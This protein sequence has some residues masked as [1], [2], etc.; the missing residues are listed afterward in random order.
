ME[1][2]QPSASTLTFCL[3]TSVLLLSSPAAGQEVDAGLEIPTAISAELDTK[4]LPRADQD[5]VLP[6]QYVTSG[7]AS[8]QRG[9]TAYHD[10]N[11]ELA[12]NEFRK[13]MNRYGSTVLGSRFGGAEGV[14][15]LFRAG[16]FRQTGSRIRDRQ[17]R[18]RGVSKLEDSYALTSYA[19][20][21][22]LIKQ[23][24]YAE[25]RRYFSKALGYDK[26][27]HDARLRIGL[28]HL[29]EGDVRNAKRRLRQLENW[30][31]D[32]VCDGEVL[33]RSVLTL[34]DAISVIETKQT[35]P[36]K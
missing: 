16:S 24:R 36:A 15:E 3:M 26:Y 18:G 17:R 21:A 29:A 32:G 9:L 28:I 34:R 1:K 13:A 30:C 25:A 7:P 11:F 8:W 2:R 19:V 14:T 12:E 4:I 33:S 22:A 20:G 31:R 5:L 27:M 10:G 23:E 6:R 35:T